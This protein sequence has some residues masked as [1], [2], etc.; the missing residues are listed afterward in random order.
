MSGTWTFSSELSADELAEIQGMIAANGLPT[1]P[2][3]AGGDAPP[4]DASDPTDDS[5]GSAFDSVVAAHPG[6]TVIRGPAF[7]RAAP[8]TANDAEAAF[9]RLMAS[10]PNATVIGGPPA[11]SGDAGADAAD[12]AFAALVAAN[13]NA[14]VIGG[15]ASG[16]T[17]ATTDA[18]ASGPA[19]ATNTWR[20]SSDLSPERLAQFQAMVAMQGAGGAPRAAAE[21][22]AEAE[23]AEAAFAAMVAQNPGAREIAPGVYACDA[24][25]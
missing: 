7:G 21:E 17:G 18:A 12:A 1:A 9:Q 25:E 13:P 24:D 10:N 2:A 15:G 3:A 5:T 20:F 23:A 16:G 19:P 6:A 22:A 14:T 4:V 8:G 11:T